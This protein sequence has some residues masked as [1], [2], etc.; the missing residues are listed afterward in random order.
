MKQNLFI[1]FCLLALVAGSFYVKS[2]SSY[3]VFV[4][5]GSETVRPIAE[6]TAE[7]K[8][9]EDIALDKRIAEQWERN[10]RT[11]REMGATGS[12]P[13]EIPLP[14]FDINELTEIIYNTVFVYM[15]EHPD[16]FPAPVE[17]GELLFKRTSDPRI[18]RLLYGETQGGLIAGFTNG[19]LAAWDVKLLN[20]D[21]TIL[22][23]GRD[24]S[25]GKW[26]VLTEGD[27]YKLRKELT[28]G[29]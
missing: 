3:A 5:A 13:S 29:D 12:L 15:G 7:E 9:L 23:L 17:D 22:V 20:G 4:A 14:L 28:D 1:A 2:R 21:Y 16:R 19:D 25:G 24:G 10:K 27:V 26:R 8:S 18:N 11:Y 6:A